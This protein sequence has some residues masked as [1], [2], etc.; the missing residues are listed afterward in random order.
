MAE[1]VPHSQ[2][3]GFVVQ[4]LLAEGRGFRFRARGASMAPAICDGDILHVIP[5]L[6]EDLRKDDIV[7]FREGMSFRAHRIVA[8]EGGQQVLT[9]QGDNCTVTDR[10]F[11]AEQLLGKV[12]AS[13]RNA[14]ENVCAQSGISSL[15][16][17]QARCLRRVKSVL[18]AAVH[19]PAFRTGLWCL[20]AALVLASSANGQVAFDTARND[21][22]RAT[23]SATPTIN[24]LH[25]TTTG[26]TNRLLV[27]GVSMNISGNTGVTISGITYNGI[28]MTQVPGGA[29]NDAGLTRRVEMWYLV[30]PFT[31]T[32]LPGVVTFN[33]PGG[34][35]TV[36][37]VI[38]SITFTGVDQT[39]PLRTFASAD[40]AGRDQTLTVGN[41]QT[42]RWSNTSGA[43]Q[44]T[45]VRGGGSTRAG[46]PSV[47]MSWTLSG[48]SNWSMGAVSVRARQ[49]DLA[50]TNV[51]TSTFFPA[52]LTYT[53]TV[54]NNG[55]TQSTGVTLTDTLAT[56]L[57][58]VSATP[59]QG[60]CTGTTTITCN[61][62]TLNGAASATVVVVANPGAVGGYPNTASVTGTTPP[63]DFNTGNNSA[64]A[65]AFSESNVC[66]VPPAP[67]AGGTLTG[68]VNTYYPGN[69]SVA[70]GATSI[71]VGTPTGSATAIA[72]GDLLLVIQMQDAAI[73]TTNGIA[74][75][76]GSSGTGWT[77]LNNAGLF[78]FAKATGAV[79]AGSVPIS[80]AGPG[81]G[82]LFAYTNAAAT[83][84]QGQRRFQVIRVP[85]YS[86]ATLS[87]TLTAAAWNGTTGGVLALDIAGTLTLNS[88]TVSVDG[89]GFRGGAGMQLSGAAGNN[90]DYVHAAPAGYAGAALAGADAPKGEGIAGT[91]L[92]VQSGGTFL[93]TGSKYPSGAAA[94]GSSA[95][96]APGTGGGG[97]TDA[98]PANNDQNAGGG[99]G[100]N[101]GAGGA[102][103]DAWNSNLSSGGLGGTPFPANSTRVVLGGGGGGG[104][105]NNSDA[106]NQASGAAAGGGIVIFRVGNMTGTA[107][108][109]A[110]GAAAYNGTA[111]DA[112][113]GGGAGGS[114]LITSVLGGTAGLTLAA[115]GGRGGDA[116][117]TQAFSIA[118][119]HGPG[120]GGG[121]GVV[122][123]SSAAAGID[124]TAGA[125]GTTLNTPAVPYGATPGIDGISQTNVPLLQQPG[126]QGGAACTPDLT[127]TKTH[128]GNFVR[129]TSNTY[130]ITV[131]NISLNAGTSGTVTVTD[132]LPTGLT[133]TAA[134]GT[135][136]TCSVAA[137]TA[138]CS[139]SNSLAAGA[140]YPAITVTVSVLQTAP[141]SVTN[142]AT[143]SGGGELITTNDTA[144]DPTTI[145]SSSDMSIT[146]TASPNPVKQGATLTFT[147]TVVN[148]GPSNATGVTVIDT[149]PS[150]VTFS[151]ATPTQGTCSFS[152]PTVTCNIGAMNSGATVTVS[153]V[154]TAGAPAVI[155]NTATVSANEPDPNAA[156]NTAVLTMTIT[157]PTQVS[158]EMFTATS[159]PS[160]VLLS[161]KTGSEVRNLG[162]NVYREE[163]GRRIR[164][165]PSVI[166]GSALTMRAALPQHTA[167]TYAWMDHSANSSNAW[168]WLEDVDLN[169]TRTLHGPVT[170][171]SGV[172]Q[173]GAATVANRTQTGMAA[174]SIA[175]MAQARTVAELNSSILGSEPDFASRVLQ[176][177]ARVTKGSSQ[178]AVQF[179]LASHP[180][181]KISVQ[182]EGW[183]RITQP[184]LVAAGLGAW[185]DPRSLQLYAE[186]VEQPIRITGARDGYG[187]FGPQAAIEFYGTGL[188]T[189]FTDKRVYWLVAGNRPGQRI[190]LGGGSGGRG[191][192][193]QSFPQTVELKQ[194]AVFFAA[195]LRDNTDNFFG[196]VV[197]TTP[198]DQVLNLNHVSSDST[199]GGKLEVVLQGVIQGAAHDVQI[200]L[201][202]TALGDLQ[203]NG[204]DEGKLVLPV[205]RDLLQEGA[206]TVTLTAQNGEDDLSLVDYVR[207][208][209]PHSYTADSDT[210]KCAA[211]SG[212]FL[213]VGG[214]QQAPTRLL[215]ITNPAQPF[216]IAS[217]A[218]KATDGYSLEAKLPSFPG[219]TRALL[220][221]TD[222]QISMPAALVANSPSTWHSPQGG[223][224]VVVVS[225]PDFAAQVAPLVQMHRSQG[226]SVALVIVD[227]LYDE[228]NFGEKSP[229]AIRDFLQ[230]ATKRWQRKPAYLLLAG[231]ASMDPRNYLGFGS[232]D[233]VPTKL[234]LTS[235]LKTASD[236]W[237]SDFN[238]TGFA[239]VTTGRL[240][241]RTADDA[242]TLIGKIVAY[243]ST[244][245]S[246]AWATQ[247]ML[248]A[249]QDDA[250]AD[251]TQ[252]A[253]AIQ[254]LLPQ[255][256][257]VS[258]VFVSTLG[259]SAAR[260]AV[261]DGINSGKLLVNYNGHGSVEV[262]SGADLLDDAS[263]SALTN[264]SR[265]PVFVVMNCLNGY[266]HDVY[267]QS[268]A[269]ALLLAKDGGAVA[270]WASSGLTSPE[271]QFQ[272]DQAFTRSLTG[273]VTP[274]LGDAIRSAKQ[275]ITDADV[276]RTFILFGDPLL[277]VWPLA[278]S[279]SPL[280]RTAPTPT[281]RQA[282]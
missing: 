186:G 155:T 144:S 124:V 263:A 131:T 110:N 50:V 193:P 89:L 13:E 214:F 278:P 142:Q 140:S 238:D 277:R 75:G 220:A 52:S 213:V 98:N 148:N 183:Y 145:V 53:I 80:G 185:S 86:T 99:G 7:L 121:G 269:E 105:R 260:Q 197:S 227:D 58:F 159:N 265:L 101:G 276:R 132:T 115:H 246:G 31:G 280:V 19:R 15:R 163:N 97:G 40:G 222:D 257:A 188:D 180:A 206:N 158:L 258:N 259:S 102:G 231:D 210:L 11:P 270:V 204:Q 172:S 153:I 215:D 146:K 221:L 33:L 182:H 275:S 68:V 248:V 175:S 82:L 235:E 49:A 94:D 187:G 56:G 112:G 274:V 192:Q 118:D 218:R 44:A 282:R 202:G 190:A 173:S 3:F 60:T 149:L 179:E 95:R 176:A 57:T 262:W 191:S 216:Q 273:Q 93:N 138:T 229:Q 59:S 39:S 120:G 96:G 108:I 177:T 157:F 43:V 245:A 252:Q 17:I 267:T 122:L 116:W 27:V 104:T 126:S 76:D 41:S 232:F 198:A 22:G 1:D 233:F 2:R 20:L 70:A 72:N 30:A 14:G 255:S 162:F 224:E 184:Q 37:A 61:L 254:A 212:D 171:Q 226:R 143:V 168:Y 209:Y 249:D 55:P 21:T 128:T 38:G 23:G 87:S 154:V 178:Q 78:E 91:P 208:T 181:V 147:L 236:D 268:L 237:F 281:I 139:R 65:V 244:P 74:Y 47:P 79:T 107:T 243:E 64:M 127:I 34:T 264:G 228:F 253:Q 67:P 271:P 12:V 32:L 48:T 135:G 69:G 125:N 167:K 217:Q 161:W 272:M 88:A 134:S 203:F 114:I 195:L 77:N 10:P 26:T 266:F 242:A 211:D 189:P 205:P 100:A 199:D 200:S 109:T 240:P 71:P 119:R 4:E 45:D 103:G 133:P 250:A 54:T 279:R 196:A 160:G 239:Q 166:A 66:V 130:T 6:F 8:I 174:A 225:A 219:G 247:A 83:N 164:L 51:P 36:G 201:N 137:P 141:S 81:G 18:R 106:D 151:S 129:G 194:R 234:V 42:Q 62:G 16:R 136:W 28:A 123:L 46:A 73:N 223:S 117:D 92:Y 230:T 152:S 111:N 35:G 85:Q 169:G 251:F 84:T 90:T 113:G 5:V 207:L 9:T 241:F 261:I 63:P 24:F 170:P 256:M 29:H 156:N 150:G 165:N 25:T